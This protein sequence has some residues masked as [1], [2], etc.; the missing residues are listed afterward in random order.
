[1]RLQELLRSKND[2][3][4]RLVKMTE[5]CLEK[6]KAG[7]FDQLARFQA[8]RGHMFEALMSFDKKIAEETKKLTRHD[9][10]EGTRLNLLG[11][12]TAGKKDLER[13]TQFDKELVQTLQAEYERI[14]DEIVANRK[15]YARMGKFKS[16]WVPESGTELDREG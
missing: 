3:L 14:T 8:R 5:E 10:T 6:I 4:N 12:H 15:A 7:N 11:E 16:S 13:L 1:M 9:L 2:V